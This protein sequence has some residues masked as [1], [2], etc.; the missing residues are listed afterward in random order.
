MSTLLASS[1]SPQHDQEYDCW[2]RNWANLLQDDQAR[3][4][5]NLDDKMVVVSSVGTLFARYMDTKL[6]GGLFERDLGIDLL[7][8]RVNSFDARDPERDT[9]LETDV[10]LIK[11]YWF[12]ESSGTCGTVPGDKFPGRDYR[13]QERA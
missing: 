2:R 11:I 9:Q 7:W 3:R 13:A 6:V 4:L 12:P 8:N 1:L 5:T 10:A